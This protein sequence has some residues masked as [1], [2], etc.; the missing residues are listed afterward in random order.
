MNLIIAIV[1]L[2]VSLTIMFAVM[3][4][5]RRQ[6]RKLSAATDTNANEEAVAENDQPARVPLSRF[7]QSIQFVKGSIGVGLVLTLVAEQVAQGATFHDGMGLALASCAMGVGI[8]F[9]KRSYAPLYA[10]FFIGSLLAVMS[11]TDLLVAARL[12]PPTH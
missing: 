12:V 1:V 3:W 4:D 8:A 6:C 11:P 10:A 9:V 2:L 5:V 7:V